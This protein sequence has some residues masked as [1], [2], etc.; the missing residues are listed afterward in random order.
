FGEISWTGFAGYR[1][2][3]DGPVT[4]PSDGTV[5][6][7]SKGIYDTVPIN[8]GAKI[9]ATDPTALTTATGNALCS[10]G[11]FGS[12]HAGGCQFCL[13]DGSVRFVAETISMNVFVSYGSAS[14]GES[15]N[16]LP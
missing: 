10:T 3:I 6:L 14:G 1:R 12:N 5:T 4:R 7:T 8:A 16:T 2:W 11:A 15:T 9:L 13:V